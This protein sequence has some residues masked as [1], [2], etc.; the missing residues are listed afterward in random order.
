MQSALARVGILIDA[1]DRLGEHG[2]SEGFGLPQD[3][4][5]NAILL[6][7][8]DILPVG[9]GLARAEDGSKRRFRDPSSRMRSWAWRLTATFPR[10]GT[11]GK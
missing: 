1:V 11:F 6:A 2:A 7:P 4:N 8:H 9:N 5:P 3:H 10:P